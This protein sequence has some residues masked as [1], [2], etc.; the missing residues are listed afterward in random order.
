MPSYIQI[1]GDPTTWWLAQPI[2]ASQLT[3]QPLS[4]Q[5]I[6][7][8]VGTLVLSGKAASVA[9]FDP[10]SGQAPNLLDVPVQAIYVPTAAGI[11]EGSVGYELPASA[12]LGTLAGQIAALMLGGNTQVVALGGTTSGGTLVLNG[13][14]LSFAVL[15]Q[16]YQAAT[17]GPIKTGSVVHG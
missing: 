5:V 4:L 12:V 11:S 7:P 3:G 1:E 15:C 17:T 16:Q 6:A 2:S 8:V 14:T 10:P 9:V 13:A